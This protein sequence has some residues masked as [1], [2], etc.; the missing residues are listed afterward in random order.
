MILKPDEIVNFAM[1]IEANGFKFYQGL[2]E[3]AADPEI[4]NIFRTL[5]GEEEKHY[6]TFDRMLREVLS[7]APPEYYMD[8]VVAYVW[9][10][11]GNHMLTGKA[12]PGEYVDKVKTP[13][14]A[15]E[16]ALAFEKDTLLFFIALKKIVFDE[17]K[18]MLDLLIDEENQHIKKLLDMKRRLAG[19]QPC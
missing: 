9:S 4:K 13:L 2:A 8:E 1:E 7:Y 16:M 15:V 18:K 10:L 6:Q 3:Q 17:G 12:G 14:D 11:A 5:A 19:K